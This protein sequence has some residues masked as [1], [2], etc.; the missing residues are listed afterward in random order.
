MVVNCRLKQRRFDLVLSIG[1]C[2]PV[3]QQSLHGGLLSECEAPCLDFR[4]QKN[5]PIDGLNKWLH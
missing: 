4:R 2:H 5:L 1:F 3:K